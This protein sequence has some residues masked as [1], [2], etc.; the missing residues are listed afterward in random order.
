MTTSQ[1]QTGKRFSDAKLETL[2]NDFKEHVRQENT[3]YAALIEKTEANTKATDKL[4][5]QMSDLI[6]IWGATKGALKVGAA[7]GTF[8]KW[9]GGIVGAGW[10][11][12]HFFLQKP[13]P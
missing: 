5:E 6:E 10:A 8:L 4:T 3:L 11:L 7:F 1:T 12:W 13:V 2:Y 9:A